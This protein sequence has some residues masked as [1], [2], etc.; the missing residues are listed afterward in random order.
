MFPGIY[1][2]RWDAGHIIF[3]GIFYSV[4]VIVLTTMAIAFQR[5]LRSFRTQ[6]VEAIRWHADFDDL[7]SSM[8]RCRHEL[9]GEIAERECPNAFDCRHCSQHPLF[10][11]ARKS[12]PTGGEPRVA[13]FELPH[14]RLYHRG[15][16]WVRP[17]ED[18]LMSVG[19]DDFASHLIGPAASLDLPKIGARIRTNGKGWK[20]TRHGVGVRVLSPIDG[21]IV[22][23]GGP[24]DEWVL[25]VK[26]DSDDTS[27]LL[28]P[29]EAKGWM[30][31]EI[32]RLQMSIAP[33]ATGATLA[34]GGVPVDDLS[35]V[36]PRDQLDDVYGMVFLHP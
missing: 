15:H 22:A 32:E 19:L 3:L 8:R 20:A 17:E 23:T 7:P 33:G 25:K 34:D 1:D 31:R 14:D 27:H 35:L 36:I 4:L 5:A 26:P 24:S 12:V 18:G 16:T 13:G 11:A 29:G 21:E 10:V 6:R 28:T 30:L 2:F 9:N